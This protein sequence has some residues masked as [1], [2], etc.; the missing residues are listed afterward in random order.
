MLTAT[1]LEQRLLRFTRE[2]LAAPELAGAITSD[3]L[4]FE[5]RVIDSLKVLELIAFLQSALGRK[6]PD[7][8]IVL[9]NFRSIATIARVFTDGSPAVLPRKRHRAV[10]SGQPSK[11][12]GVAEL[13]ARRELELTADGGLTMRGAAASLCEYFDSVVRGWAF[14]LGAI[15]ET[16]PSEI[17]L[18]TLGR[19][20]FTTAFPEKLVWTGDASDKSAR[21]PAVCYHHYPRVSDSTLDGGASI[22]TAL[23]R[24]FRNEYD[25]SSCH[26]AE[27]LAAFTMREIIAVGDAA[28]V[29]QLRS[30]LMDR[31]STWMRELALDGHVEVAT[32]PFFTSEARGRMLMQQ[33]LPLKYELR[34]RVDPDGR[35]VAAASFN[36][37]QQ[38]FGRAFSILLPSG[39]HAHSGCVA[40]GW[41]RWMIAFVNQ[42]G[43]DEESWPGIVRSTNVAANV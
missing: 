32:D 25:A 6:I 27:R 28:V 35:S 40:F 39:E 5:D 12:S 8:Q 3:T 14:E 15:E 19:A 41:E 42:H 31:V 37:H 4:L 17:P 9:A 33:M 29:E 10:R 18:A 20:G 22:V 26:P 13:F 7:A 1:E 21:P 43:P 30:D 11:R 38:H 2:T 24:C 36:N 23:G 16:F 34:L